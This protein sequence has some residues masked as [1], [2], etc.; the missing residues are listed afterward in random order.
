MTLMPEIPPLDDRSADVIA[1]C[2]ALRR[3]G[4]LPKQARCQEAKAFD[5]G[6]GLPAAPGWLRAVA[7]GFA[8]LIVLALAGALFTGCAYTDPIR[9]LAAHMHRDASAV[10]AAHADDVSAAR[11]LTATE[12]LAQRTGEPSAPVAVE[13]F[14]TDVTAVRDESTTRGRIVAAAESV[15]VTFWAILAGMAGTLVTAM[16]GPPIVR[17]VGSAVAAGVQWLRSSARRAGVPEALVDRVAEEAAKRLTETRA[18][19]PSSTTA[20]KS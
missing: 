17:R 7:L 2:A 13:E 15:G 8:V 19:G 10:A 16:V 20:S 18:P 12:A 4:G 14:E 3:Q 9:R 1:A 11:L 5:R 6:F